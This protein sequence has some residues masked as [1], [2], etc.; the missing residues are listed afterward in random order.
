M[1]TKPI[2][3]VKVCVDCVFTRF[4]NGESITGYEC[5]AV[6]PHIDRVSG[7]ATFRNCVTVRK[8]ETLCGQ[9]GKWYQERPVKPTM[10]N[11]IIAMFK[12]VKNGFREYS[13]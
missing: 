5:T 6:E 2:K 12:S 1:E 13:H 11:K 3:P 4:P 9:S 8:D 10:T 7:R